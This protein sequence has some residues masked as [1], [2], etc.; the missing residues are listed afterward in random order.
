MKHTGPVSSAT[1]DGD[2][3]SMVSGAATKSSCSAYCWPAAVTVST[4]LLGAALPND[5]VSHAVRVAPSAATCSDVSTRRAVVAA[6]LPCAGVWPIRPT[7]TC[8]APGANT[9]V[10]P[11]GTCS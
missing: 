4:E 1:V 7:T 2:D 10:S 11:V 5:S 6:V 3:S 9:T 8:C